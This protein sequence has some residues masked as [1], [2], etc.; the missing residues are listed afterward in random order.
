MSATMF[1]KIP[2]GA[3]PQPEQFKVQFD[4]EKL[5]N[6]KQLIR[7]SPVA[8]DCYENQNRDQGFG[9]TRQWMLD[10]K[11]YWEKQFD[12]RQ[13][14]ENI[15]STPQFM[16]R[17]NDDGYEFKIHF[18]GLFS[19]RADAV[20][21]MLLHGWPGSF[22]EFL[23]ILD[24][25]KKRYTPDDLPYHIICPSLPGYALST[26]PPLDRNWGIADTAR[27]MHKLMLS[28]G[29]QS[30]MVQG[31]DIGSYVSRS[32]AATYSECKA[33][34]LNFCM[35]PKPEDVPD[36]DL[37]PVERDAIE[38]SKFFVETAT[39]YG[40]MHAQRPATI[41]HMLSSSPLA[42]L[43]WIGEKFLEWTDQDLPL[44][45][46]LADITLYWLCESFP[47]SIY[48]YREDFDVPP[49]KGFYHS[50]E[51][52]YVDK[53]IGYS[54][55]PY[56]LIAIPKA[57]AATTGNLVWFKR[58]DKGGHFAALERPQELLQD[59]EDFVKVAWK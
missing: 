42:L 13:V 54:Y 21:I 9:V 55:F 28:L 50:Q 34:H 26:Q 49:R 35:M 58:H 18:C 36:T 11:E 47:T 32:I 8:K 5:N 31:G 44:D 48:T 38:R 59:I 17:I 15:N 22:L 52:L 39:A 29:F 7:L 30:Y 51:G 4:E 41:G 16:Q 20:P 25:L 2:E 53:P 33:M 19:N 45:M 1:G 57:W 40:R 43:A 24:L 46:V 10:T 27:I 56:E 14:E 3:S 12:W 37:E 6:L 23:H